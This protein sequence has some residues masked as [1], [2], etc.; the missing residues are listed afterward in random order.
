MEELLVEDIDRIIGRVE[1]FFYF[2][3]TRLFSDL[4]G[5]MLLVYF[6]LIF[7]D[8]YR[9]ILIGLDLRVDNW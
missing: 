4:F 9:T 6:I 3:V 5:A 8:L 2:N 7:L 1:V